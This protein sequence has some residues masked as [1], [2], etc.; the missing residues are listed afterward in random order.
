MHACIFST[1]AGVPTIS[2][3]YLYKLR[4]YMANLGLEDFSIDIEEF[5]AEW[6]MAA[7]DRMWLRRA[8]IRQKIQMRM[9]A[10]RTL[11]QTSMLQLD[12]LDS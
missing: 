11:L 7:F 1:G 8:E 4:E 10:N 3:N 2:V 6:M 9:D 12:A 5:N